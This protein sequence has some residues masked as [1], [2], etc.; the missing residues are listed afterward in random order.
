MDTAQLMRALLTPFSSRYCHKRLYNNV[1]KATENTIL[2]NY[3]SLTDILLN[4]LSLAAILFNCLGLAA[5][6]FNY[7]ILPDILLNYL[8]LTAILIK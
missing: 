6:L 2:F 3:L 7:L 8:R 5:I 4:Y 1:F